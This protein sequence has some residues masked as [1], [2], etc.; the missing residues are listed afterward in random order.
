MI[1]IMIRQ[2]LKTFYIE[3]NCK[4]ATCRDHIHMNKK[5][6]ID[7]YKY[8]FLYIKY[9]NLVLIVIVNMQGPQE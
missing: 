6:K 9:F 1:G 7:K 5:I 2:I 8:G 4:I 3:F